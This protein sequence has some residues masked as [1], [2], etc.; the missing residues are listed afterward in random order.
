MIRK[1]RIKFIAIS[2]TSTIIVLFLILG[3]INLLNYREMSHNAD[4]ILDFLKENDG[5]LPENLYKSQHKKTNGIS[6]ETS[7]ESR[8]FSVF[9]SN[10]R[11]ICEADTDNISAIDE[12]TAIKYAQKINR[13]NKNCG[14][15]SKYR[16]MKENTSNGVKIYF[17]DCTKSMM[18]FQTFLVTSFFVSIFGVSTVFI[19][20]VLLSKRAIEPVAESYEKQK[21]FITD[22]GHEIKTPL[23]IIDA[24]TSI[25]EM[26]YGENE[27]LDDIQVQTKRLAGLTNDLI[28]LSRMEEKQTKTTMIEFP[29]SEVI[30]EE[31]QSFQ[32]LAK[33]K[34]KNFT[35][36]ELL[37][38]GAIKE[39]I[40]TLFMGFTEAE[41]VK[42]F[43][44]TY[45]ALRVS[46]FN[47]LDTYAEMKGLNTQQI[48]DGVCLDPRIG[49]HYNNP[50]FGYGGYCLPKDTKQLL[51][52]YEDVP[53]NMMSAIVESNK[54][55]KDFIAD[56]VLDKAGYY[57]SNSEWN[58]DF[59]KKIVIGVFRLT[60]KSNSDNFRQS[61]IQGVMKRVK[62]KGAEVIIYE[63]TLK[64]GETFFGSVVVND[65][66]KFKEMSDAIIA[67]RYDPCLDDVEDK[68]YTRDIF[69]RD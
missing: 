10:N 12:E 49:T 16:Y 33:V 61:S 46:Y 4:T 40:D 45:L 6:P 17:L 5:E 26:E 64:D 60:M 48:I 15:I 67:N 38:Q 7:F 62:A 14:F 22:A 30:S 36:A 19:L 20:V 54:T 34:G 32:G 43:A 69:R 41:A 13:S 3:S 25:L 63:P 27:W 50:S 68:V 29:F 28:F 37:Q 35:F 18:S 56:R 52:N 53:Q 57:S 65:L 31:A 8:Y 23:T 11:Q 44:N 21:R 59:E 39:N 2:M 42:L 1:L 51:A 58:A 24:D 47:E 9:L 66:A 55:R